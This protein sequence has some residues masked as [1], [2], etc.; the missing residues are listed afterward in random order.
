MRNIHRRL[1][2]MLAAAAIITTLPAAAQT[3]DYGKPGEPIKLTVGYVFATQEWS[4]VIQKAKG[5][6]KKYLPAGSD[7][8]F[9]ASLVGLPIVGQMMAGTMHVGYLGDMPSIISTTKRDVGDIRIAAVTSTSQQLCNVLLVRKDAP[10]FKSA[11]EAIRWLDGKIAATPHGSCA[12]RFARAAFKKANVKTEKYF[13]WSTDQ[14][15]ENFKS[16][17]LDGAVLWEPIPTKLV[18]DGVVKRVGSGVNFNEFEASFLIMRRDLMTARPD[19]LKA[20]L[21]AELD[22][23]LFLAD[24]KNADEIISIVEKEAPGY[25]KKAL[26]TSLYG[27]YG[28]EVG[29]NPDRLTLDFIVSPKVNDLIKGTLPDGAV[30]DEA[31]RQVLEGRKLSSPLATIK[32]LPAGSF[33][34]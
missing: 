9:E 1:S 27:Q 25:S 12:D 6:W 19:I 32:A 13:N 3:T 7:V 8:S 26:W 24:P 33:K 2:S 22:T 4:P 16:G 20:W 28:A 31:A 18:A 14:I 30:S 15:I 17:K 5:F 21:E 29:G 23:Q 10:D 11:D 34:E